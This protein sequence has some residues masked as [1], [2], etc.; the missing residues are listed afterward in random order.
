M[1]KITTPCFFEGGWIPDHNAGYGEDQSPEFHIEGIDEKAETMIITLDD[2]GHPLEPGYNHWI[3]WN[4]APAE[5]IP[6]SIPKGSVVENPIHIEIG[7]GKGSF[8]IGMAKN[9]PD[10]NYIGIEMYDSVLVR[11][12]ETLETQKLEIPN[13]KL[14]LFDAIN[15]TPIINAIIAIIIIVRIVINLFFNFLFLFLS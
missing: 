15:F 7:M 5:C 6:G 10:I 9:N 12:V 2:L 1:L 14:L 3:A 11:A 4:I 13:L 8:I